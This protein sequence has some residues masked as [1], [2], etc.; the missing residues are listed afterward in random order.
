MQHATVV[1]STSIN[2]S[3]AHRSEGLPTWSH[4]CAAKIQLCTPCSCTSCAAHNCGTALYIM[5]SPHA[6]HPAAEC[7]R[8]SPAHNMQRV[9]EHA[10]S[11][12]ARHSARTSSE[13]TLGCV[14]PRSPCTNSFTYVPAVAAAAA[15]AAV[16]RC[17]GRR[18]PSCAPADVHSRSRKKCGLSSSQRMLCTILSRAMSVRLC[19]TR[20]AAGR[21]ARAAAPRPRRA[22]TTDLACTAAAQCPAAAPGRSAPLRLRGASTTPRSCSGAEG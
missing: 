17:R 1:D 13:P 21:H 10:A 12:V 6:P 5:P 22:L 11:P 18:A 14:R 16:T 15:A 2:D 19:S 3:R 7:L 8:G 4:G 9:S 20:T